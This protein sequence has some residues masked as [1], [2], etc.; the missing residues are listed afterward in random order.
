MENITGKQFIKFM[1]EY[2]GMENLGRA[3]E[4]INRFKLDPHIKIKKM[5]K[6]MKQKI[7]LVLAFMHDPDVLILDESTSGLNPLMQSEFVKL[8]LEEKKRGKTI[9]MSSHIFEEIEKT[10]DRVGIIRQGKIVSID[11]VITLKKSKQKI[12]V[13]TFKDN[14]DALKFKNEHFIIKEINNN[15]TEVVIKDEINE[16]I[17]CLNKYDLASLDVVNQGIE[18]IFMQF[19]GG[20]QDV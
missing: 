10:C 4:I 18:E 5:S 8:V 2:Q 9:L 6:V 14:K 13:V 12:Y 7:G 1:A 3:D 17:S 15:V 16:L 19:Y 11:D 20:V